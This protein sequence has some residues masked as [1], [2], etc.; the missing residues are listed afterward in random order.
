MLLDAKPCPYTN[1]PAREEE[2]FR[3]I[4]CL[5]FCNS[6]NFKFGMFIKVRLFVRQILI[7]TYSYFHF[8]FHIRDRK[9]Y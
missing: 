4:S 5:E 6:L 2:I 1:Q 3:P 7:L 9:K 8:F